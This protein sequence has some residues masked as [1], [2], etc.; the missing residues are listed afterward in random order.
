MLADM[1]IQTTFE[2]ETM[3]RGRRAKSWKEILYYG[4]VEGGWA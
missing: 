2:G 1:R 4:E 3:G